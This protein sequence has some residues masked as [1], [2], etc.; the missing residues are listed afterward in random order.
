MSTREAV[1]ST[2]VLGN[3]PVNRSPSSFLTDSTPGPIFFATCALRNARMV[4]LCQP[5]ALAISAVVAPS[6]HRRNSCLAALAG[7]GF[8]PGF[9]GCCHLLRAPLVPARSVF[10]RF[11]NRFSVCDL[12]SD[13]GKVFHVFQ[14]VAIFR[15]CKTWLDA[16]EDER[17]KLAERRSRKMRWRI[18]GLIALAA[19]ALRAHLSRR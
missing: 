6:F 8:L 14:H 9:R 11:A 4:W 16:R 13:S 1:V 10:S 17:S 19:A 18:G 2:V 12:W 7:P 5:V 3:D 15:E